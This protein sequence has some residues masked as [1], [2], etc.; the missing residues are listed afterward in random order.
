M[1]S[2]VESRLKNI[3]VDDYL[4]KKDQWKRGESSVGIG[5]NATK[6]HHIHGCQYQSKIYHFIHH[7]H[8]VYQ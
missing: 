3:K 6:V 2:Y 5:I 4:E 1:F 8:I 7:I